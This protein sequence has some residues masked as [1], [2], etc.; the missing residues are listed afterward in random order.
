MEG[1]REGGSGGS[2]SAYD[3]RGREE[4]REGGREGTNLLQILRRI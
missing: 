1:G 4:E 2:V 3:E